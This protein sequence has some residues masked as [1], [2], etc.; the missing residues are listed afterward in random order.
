M[1]AVAVD[2][3]LSNIVFALYGPHRIPRPWRIVGRAAVI[4]PEIAEKLEFIK[5]RAVKVCTKA[6][7]GRSPE[8]K[9]LGFRVNS[10]KNCLGKGKS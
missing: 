7:T 4:E 8:H 1:A 3:V 6:W 5:V 9:N 10:R 2:F